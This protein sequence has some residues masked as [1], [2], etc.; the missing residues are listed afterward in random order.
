MK[1]TLL[2]ILLFCSATLF[3]QIQFPDNVINH[4][5]QNPIGGNPWDIGL[6]KSNTSRQVSSYS[7]IVA[8]DINGDGITDIVVAEYVGN[9]YR[10]NRILVY[11]G[12]D[13]SIQYNFS[14]PDTIYLSNGPYAIGRYPLDNG[15]MQGAIFT[16]SYDN[17]IRSYSIDGTLLNVSDCATSCYGM[18]SLAD[19]NHDGHPEVYAG[20]A[21][22]DAATLKLLCVGPENGNKG[23]SYRGS[24]AYSNGS[25]H[26]TYYAMSFAYNVL[27][28]DNL[29]LI[30]GNTIYNVNI[31]SRTNPSSNSITVNKTITPPYGYSQDGHVS[32]ADFDLDGESEVLIMRDNTNDQIVDDIYFYAY[33][34]SNGNIIFNKTHRCASSS[35]VFIGNIDT[36]PH[37]E[38]I[39]L[40]NQPNGYQEKIFCWRYTPQDNLKTIWSEYHSDRSGQTAMT[41]FDFNQ[42]EIME[43]IYRDNSNLRIINASGK[44]HITNND[45]IRPYYIYTRK[46]SAG[47]GCEYPIVADINNDGHAEIVVSGVLDEYNYNDIGYGGLHAFGSPESWAPARQ[48]WNQYM[49]NVTNVNNDLTIPDF[50]F[51]NATVFQGSQG[52]IR[53][54]FNNFLQQATYINQLGEPF[55]PN[56]AIETN[57]YGEGC[58]SFS[59]HGTTYT[60]NGVYEQLIENHDGCD[61]LAIVHVNL[62][63]DVFHSFTDSA[64]DSYTW[65]GITYKES[66]TYQQTFTSQQGCDSIV[67]LELTIAPGPYVSEIVGEQFI[68]VTDHGRYTYSIEPVEGAYDYV[69]FIDN[70]W[71]ISNAVGSNSCTIDI[72]TIG[73][74]TL[75]VRVYSEC[76]YTERKIHIEH[77]LQPDIVVFPNPTYGDFKLYL[78]GMDGE[79]LIEIYNAI[80][81]RIAQFEANATVGGTLL[82]YSLKYHACGM[83]LISVTN[84]YHN[85]TKKLVK[86][87]H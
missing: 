64:C 57:I 12:N 68:Y 56:G 38:I 85:V 65:N 86:N 66:G 14:V 39:F 34:P 80:G 31:V 59:Y 23:L 7:P 62:G 35:Y 83:Y 36:D 13:L 84:R 19:F 54:P 44:S 77:S 61:T 51:N 53:R 6:L 42:D 30:C 11:N 45:T 70:N 75:T 8:G 87:T 79:T 74:G 33:K 20:N 26:H 47:T 81:Q 16:H 73:N 9:N 37:P 29:E 82:D 25:Y 10:S 60:E 71:T 63:K 4:G 46:M 40:E 21:V 2:L 76:G 43:L 78:Y 3:A 67:Q 49:Y 72:N 28:D 17:R 15:E 1:K 58:N 22:F 32:I 27:G 69:W 41:L 5:C 50:T 52:A 48:V 55:N 24:P 18:V